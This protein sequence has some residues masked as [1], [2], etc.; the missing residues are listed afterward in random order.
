MRYTTIIDITELTAIYRNV[1]ARLIYLH[2]ALKA[3]YHD[4]DRDLV[5]I[6]IRRLAADTGLS[7]AATRHALRQLETAGLVARQGGVMIVRKWLKEQPISPR[8][9]T[10]KQ[11]RAAT[12]EAQRRQEKEAYERQM[13]AEAQSRENLAAQGKNAFIVYYEDLLKRAEQGDA[14]AAATAK[15]R[16]PMYEAEIAKMKNKE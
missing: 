7:V 12:I 10:A 16:R 15:R 13:A 4:N 14:E 11:Q 2:L 8:A 6:S 9:R 1:N 3:G 5:D